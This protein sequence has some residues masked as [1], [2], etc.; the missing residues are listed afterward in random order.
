[1]QHVHD[2]HTHFNI[3]KKRRRSILANRAK[4]LRYRENKKAK[5]SKQLAQLWK[6][7]ADA[8]AKGSPVDDRNDSDKI[9]ING[10]A[11][12]N[13]HQM[14]SK[15]KADDTAAIKESYE[16]TQRDCELDGMHLL[17]SLLLPETSKSIADNRLIECSSERDK[18]LKDALHYRTL[19]EKLETDLAE[20]KTTMH[21]RVAAVRDFWRNKVL[22]G[23]SRS[24]M[25][26]RCSLM[27]NKRS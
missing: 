18:A 17:P 3:Q 15:N 4:R 2:T 9:D 24:G 23:E 19:V 5:W 12:S 11:T 6:D 27:T 20:L 25:I 21:H 14:S 1:M 16:N 7:R 22:E 10:G 8:Y 26:L 13:D